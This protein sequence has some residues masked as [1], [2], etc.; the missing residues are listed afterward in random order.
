MPAVKIV[1]GHGTPKVGRQQARCQ[2]E[3]KG[4][5]AARALKRLVYAASDVDAS[6]LPK[7]QHSVGNFPH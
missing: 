4:C 5:S 1:V 2:V 7:I 3:A 6:H